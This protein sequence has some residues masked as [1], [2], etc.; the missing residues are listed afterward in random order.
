ML[1]AVIFSPLLISKKRF[2]QRE[3]FFASH[4]VLLPKTN[5]AVPP[6]YEDSSRLLQSGSYTKSRGFAYVRRG[7]SVS[8]LFFCILV[9]Y[10]HAA[11]LAAHRFGQLVYKFHHARVFI[12]RR[13]I[14]HMRLE[15][16]FQLLRRFK[17]AREHDRRFHDLSAYR[18]RARPLPRIPVRDGCAQQ[19]AFHLERPDAVARA[20]DDVVVPA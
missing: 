20:L 19:G 7:F 3:R 18:G 15:F 9:S 12:G 2:W 4:P 14:L 11:S 17:S 1:P 10:P 5:H 13:H 6:F 16:F 8:I